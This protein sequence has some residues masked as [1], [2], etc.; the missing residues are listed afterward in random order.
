MLECEGHRW[1]FDEFVIPP[2][3]VMAWREAQS[4]R[5]PEN[6]YFFKCRCGASKELMASELT[7]EQRRAFKALGIPAP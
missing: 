1:V 3:L 2:A 4:Q 7:N 5:P 6:I